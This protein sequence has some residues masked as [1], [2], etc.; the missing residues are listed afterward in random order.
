MRDSVR[1][2]AA[3]SPAPATPP[4]VI[5]P[6]TTAG[7]VNFAIDALALVAP[8]HVLMGSAMA[9]A[10]PDE[11][12][13]ACAWPAAIGFSVIDRSTWGVSVDAGMLASRTWPLTD[14]GP[15]LLVC[16]GTAAS[17]CGVAGY[18][19]LRERIDQRSRSPGAVVG[20]ALPIG[21]VRCAELSADLAG[22]AEW[23]LDCDVGGPRRVSTLHLHDGALSLVE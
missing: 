10:A 22:H 12:S 4:G 21:L 18:Q 16:L 15:G 8:G 19:P 17:L 6:R 1:A 7:P 3:R 23:R 13:I 9:H 14:A 20:V 2:E 11:W 5:E